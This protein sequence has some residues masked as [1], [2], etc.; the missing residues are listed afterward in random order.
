LGEFQSC[1]GNW[2]IGTDSHIGLNPLEELRLLDYGQ[3]VTTHRRNTFTGDGITDSGLY[4]I[5]KATIAGRRAMNN[6]EPRFFSPGASFDACVLRADAPLLAQAK[7][8]NLTS[9]IVYS[10]DASQ[11][12]GTFVS[13]KLIRTDDNYRR[14]RAGFIECVKEFR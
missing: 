9:S 14:I 3:R 1:G 4:A 5:R 11:F 13:G 7:V 2:S 8:E 6:H 12:Y 10:A